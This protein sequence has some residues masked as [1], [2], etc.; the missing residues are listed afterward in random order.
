MAFEDKIIRGEGFFAAVRP[1]GPAA[2]GLT[3]GGVSRLELGR[4]RCGAFSEESAL[5][6]KLRRHDTADALSVSVE[7]ECV[8]PFGCEYRAARRLELCDGFARWTVDVAPVGRGAVEALNLED[9][10]FRGPWNRLEYLLFGEERFRTAEPGAGET[11]FYR[12]EEIPWAVRLISA[13]GVR[14]EFLTAGDLWRHRAARRMTGARSEF[15]LRGSATELRFEREIFRFG[16]ESVIERRPWR[17]TNLIVW[18]DPARPD[19]P[20]PEDERTVDLAA[21][22]I[23]CLCGA[24]A[25]RFLRAAIRRGTGALRLENAA[26]QLCTDAAHLERPARQTLEHCDVGD[27]LHFYLWGNRQLAASGGSLRITSKTGTP[28]ADSAAADNLG[29]K[30]RPLTGEKDF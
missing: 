27:A 3:V 9:V 2:F 20:P 7:S 25:R 16:P 8:I 15:A 12:G 11:E 17:F 23:G 14:V 30:L 13:D 1:E 18:S 21:E 22:G 6:K 19:E 5:L 28:L 10:V 26:L 4:I 29:R 24:A